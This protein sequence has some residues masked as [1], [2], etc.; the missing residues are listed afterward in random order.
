MIR[1]TVHALAACVVTFVLC[2][3]IYPAAVWGLGQLA[4]PQHAE[5]SLIYSRDRAV[6]GSE[7]IAQPFASDKYFQPRPSAA[8]YK[9]D[10]ASGSN[11]GTKNPDLRAKVKE[12]AEALKATPENPAP[13]DLISASGS[14]LDPDISPGGA[15]DQAARVAAARKLPIAQVRSLIDRLTEHSG[16]IIGGPPRVNVLRLNRALDE[17]K[18]APASAP[19]A[20][21]PARPDPTGEIAALRTELGPISD[22]LKQMVDRLEKRAEAIDRDKTAQENAR[23]E[24]TR[25]GEQ[26]ARLADDSRDVPRL[27]ER[28]GG[29]DARV[30]S[31]SEALQALRSEV[32]EA[33]ETLKALGQA[34]TLARA[35]Q[36]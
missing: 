16:S 11:L 4:F 36:R 12:R 22:Q 6:I 8:D 5:G 17:E 10:A 14:G 35:G 26:V 7:L 32:K 24:L 19:A 31:A 2:A 15:R 33:R 20:D 3:V 29:L 9:A 1:E 21:A 34:S 25:W 27:I 13:A 28:V 18:P 23:A 30:K